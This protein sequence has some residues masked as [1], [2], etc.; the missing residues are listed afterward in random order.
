M[1]ELVALPNLKRGIGIASMRNRHVQASNPINRDS[2]LT[3]L[4]QLCGS[5]PSLAAGL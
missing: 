5:R 1:V 4:S 2:S 3:A